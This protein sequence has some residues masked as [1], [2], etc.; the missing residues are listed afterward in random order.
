MDNKNEKTE[1]LFFKNVPQDVDLAI[2]MHQLHMKHV[3]G[4]KPNLS[5]VLSDIVREWKELKNK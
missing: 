3:K 1:E 2:R 4:F 5:D